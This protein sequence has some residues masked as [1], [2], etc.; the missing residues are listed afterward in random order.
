MAEE[1]ILSWSEWSEPIRMNIETDEM[2]STKFDEIREC[3]RALKNIKLKSHFEKIFTRQFVHPPHNIVKCVR[4]AQGHIQ[5]VDS[6]LNQWLPLLWPI[7]I[8]RIIH[9]IIIFWTQL[10][11]I[12]TQFWFVI[13][14]SAFCVMPTYFD[15]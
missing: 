2:E 15:F 6:G 8:L 3:K 9:K 11:M 5:L 4:A 10:L 12:L 13:L 7:K 1:R 14:T